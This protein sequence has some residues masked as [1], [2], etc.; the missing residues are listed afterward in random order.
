MFSMRI[1]L[2]YDFKM[3]CQSSFMMHHLAIMK[4]SWRLTRKILTGQKK[5]ES[6]WYMNK[7]APWNT[8]SVG[9][10]VY[11]KD[12]GEPVK[13]AAEVESVM[14]FEGLTPRKVREILQRYGSDD[15]ISVEDSESFIKRFSN[16]RYC[17]LIFLKN[18]R[19]VEPFNI[20]KKGYGM[21]SAWISVDDINKIRVK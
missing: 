18:P 15:G 16:K 11:F 3:L 1:A 5:I 7:C 2:C 8:I 10:T 20:N 6:R 13:L 9:D 21:M 12:S 4:K 19:K 14:K 17:M